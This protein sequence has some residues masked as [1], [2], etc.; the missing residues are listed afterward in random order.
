M[1]GLK[2]VLKMG[3]LLRDYGPRLKPH[4][5]C[6]PLPRAEARCYSEKASITSFS[7]PSEA[8]TYLRSKSSQREGGM[9]RVVA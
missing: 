4:S 8:R 2:R 3:S 1:S 6:V 5:F 7:A 9:G